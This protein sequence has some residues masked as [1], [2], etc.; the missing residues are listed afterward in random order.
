M[1]KTKGTVILDKDTDLKFPHVLIIDAS[2]GTGKTHTLTQRYVQY[3]LSKTIPYNH[4]SN[5]LAITFTNNA[6]REMKQRIL[7]WLK[8]LA[9]GIDCEEREQTLKLVNL[10]PEEIE[11]QARISLDY[12]LRHWTDFHIQT[13][14]SFM[15]RI[16]RASAHEIGMPLEIEIS[17]SYEVLTD[18]ALDIILNN[19]GEE[20]SQKELERFLELLNQEASTFPW[21]PVFR[22]IKRFEEFLQ[23]EGKV[24]EEIVFEDKLKLIDDNFAHIIEIY[25]DIINSGFGETIKD[26]IHKAVNNRDIKG[27][28]GA[29]DSNFLWFKKTKLTEEAINIC[30]GLNKIVE[31]L[32]LLYASSHYYHYGIFYKNF[33]KILDIEKIKNEII[34]FDDINKILSKYIKQDNIPE[35]YYRLGDTLYHFMLDEFQDTDRVQWE[36]IQPLLFEAY[37]KGGSFFAVGDM[38]QAIYLFRKA[39]Y[40]IMRN[41]VQ[42]IKHKDRY[43][44][45]YLPV[46]VIDNARIA[47]LEDN[48]RSGNVILNYVDSIFKNKLKQIQD[49]ICLKED[50]TGL[51]EYMHK[52]KKK[53][54]G[55][56][57]TIILDKNEEELEKEVL[58]E[59]LADI[60]KRYKPHDIAI[61]A[62]K[63]R[64]IEKIVEW[65]TEKSIATASFSSLNVKKRKII[66][67]IV[68][69]LQFLDSPIDNLSFA[70]FITGDIFLSA[71]KTLNRNIRLEDMLSF[72]MDVLSQKNNTDNLYVSFRENLEFAPLWEKFFEDIF[73]KVGYYPLYD[74][75]CQIL[76]IFKV[77]DNFKEETGFLTR[78]LETISLIE[79]KGMNSVKDFLKLV[80]EEQE[81]SLLNIMLPDYIDAV[82]VMTFHK[83]KGLGFPVV[84]NMIYDEGERYHNMFF[85]KEGENLKIY[86]IL[87]NFYDKSSELERIYSESRLDDLIQTL[88]LLY[89]ANT[90]AMNELYNIVIR[91]N[92]RYHN[93]CL[94]IFDNF[95]DGVKIAPLE[96]A[97]ERPE[98]TEIKISEDYKIEFFRQE[99]KNWSI[100]RILETRK[101]EFFH[102]ILSDIDFVRS[103]IDKKLDE[104]INKIL[105]KSKEIYEMEGVK[106]TILDFL[107]VEIVR[108]WF[109]EKPERQVEREVEYV[110]EQGLLYRLDRIIIDPA[111]VTIIDFKTG[112]EEPDNYYTQMKNYIKI[113]KSLYQQREVKGY[114]AFIETKK[115]IE[116]K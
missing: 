116:I 60:L 4:P 96:E 16:L 30:K 58:L 89:V 62:R 100:N 23:E 10:S 63:N 12:I 67:E 72:I 45:S 24:L 21:N 104:I 101:G 92:D 38:K 107:D 70:T 17:E 103:D 3:I 41:I 81:E 14:D 34:H 57:K 27:F 88:N 50:R 68:S 51:T 74:L 94:N 111:L 18:S 1:A 71:V 79:A 9:L 22:I 47:T 85:D 102:E 113:L 36:N 44:T 64:H 40:R 7:D 28:L 97:V 95:E 48:F 109:N 2:A 66:M 90:R 61:L 105:A 84:I 15:S 80:A 49:E 83:A 11:N 110:D 5:I 13:I 26:S 52:A 6:A 35:I 75:T 76:R 98:P 82:K 54:Q 77:F 56:V 78:F 31:E 86:Y 29:F 43:D 33:K 8:K 87:K 20:I 39:D 73:T 112:N 69:L 99:E 55:Y 32:A 115:I 108:E 25:K 114:I 53:D 19:I 37:A 91:R 93:L 65:L 106:K 42:K 46:N 59:I